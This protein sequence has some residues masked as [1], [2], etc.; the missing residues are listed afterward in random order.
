MSPCLSARQAV[1]GEDEG[2]TVG[3]VGRSVGAYRAVVAGEGASPAQSGAAAAG[4]S[5]LSAGNPVRAAHRDP[6][7]V[8]AA[9]A[10]LRSGDDVL[11][12]AAGLARGRC[13][14]PPSSGAAG[15]TAPCR[16]TRL[17]AGG[18]RRLAPAGPPGRPKTGPGPVDRARPGPKHHVITDG[19]G[20]PLAITLTGGNR[21]D[22]TQLPPLPDAIPRIRGARGRPRHRPRMLFADRGYDFDKPRRLL[23]QRGI[24]PGIAHR[25]YRTAPAP[26]PYAGSSSAPTPGSTASDTR[27]SAGT[28][29]TTSTKPSSNPPAA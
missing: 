25:A 14:G 2:A 7:G 13:V 11:A 19:H 22:V 26:A 6:V 27:A 10:R 3:G 15:R 20:T 23:R 4:R 18:D 24:R 12:P 21:H 8:A 1:R 28:S 29:A 16:Q 9:G 17:V 5:R